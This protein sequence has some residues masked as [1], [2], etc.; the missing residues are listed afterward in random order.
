M[1]SRNAIVCALIAAAGTTA[2]AGVFS[3]TGGHAG[4][5]NDPA[6]WAGPGGTYPHLVTDSATISG[7]SDSVSLVANTALG[8]LNILGGAS[9]YS[10][11]HSLFVDGDV[12]INGIG[13]ALSVSD[14]PALR[15][16]DV[17]SLTIASGVVAMYGGLMQ[18][19]DSVL[20]DG[21]NG[22]AILGVGTV[23]MN[24]TTGD[25]VVGKGGLWALNGAGPETTLLIDR[26]ESSTSRLDM[27]HPESDIIVWDGKAVHN[28][29]P[30]AGTLGGEIRVSNVNGPSRFISDEGFIAAPS[31]RISFSGSDQVE[32]ARIDAAFM[33]SYGELNVHSKGRLVSPFVGLRGTGVIDE[34]AEIAIDSAAMLWHSFSFSATGPN[35]LVRFVDVNG[36]VSVTGGATVFDLGETGTFDLDGGG[37]MEISIADG[38]SLSIHAGSVDTGAEV[39][40]GTLNVA[41]G[42]FVEYYGWPQ[43]GWTSSGAINMQG[44]EITG[45]RFINDGTISGKGMIDT[46][47]HNDGI[48]EAVGGTLQF[49]TLDLDGSA[50]LPGTGITR[51]EEGDIV[52]TGNDVGGFHPTAGSLYV[53]NGVG[54]RE[55]FEMNNGILLYENLEGSG[56]MSLNGGFARFGRA[57]LQTEFV[58]TNDS[59][60]TISGSGEHD[61]LEFVDG[62]A[63]INGPLEV[64]GNVIVWDDATLTG[65]GTID[66][67]STVQGVML[68]NGSSTGDVSIE[69]SGGI[70]VGAYGEPSGQASAAGLM[71][72]PT[73]H[74]DVDIAGD[75]GS[76]LF[77]RL[78]IAGD[79]QVDG[80]LV[81]R[82]SAELG[83]AP[84]G[85]TY[86]VLTAGSVSGGFDGVDFSGLGTNRRAQV[87]VHADSVEVLV[88]CLTDLNAD[89]ILDLGDIS[90]FT[91]AFTDGDMLADLAPP[92]GV[93]DLNDIN[94]FVFFFQ[95]GCN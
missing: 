33:D 79:A 23:E 32:T 84:V 42:F 9:V 21:P 14:S 30:Y 3:W 86:T 45:R 73:A 59:I 51:A 47:V 89:G 55:V 74:L 57:R 54:I 48:I 11:G 64:R 60:V 2:S 83:D 77:D 43:L 81:V 16:L 38:S 52:V 28:R 87:S 75:E 69:A 67:S 76:G 49:A 56:L 22:G 94:A 92:F 18:V 71:M 50:D 4:V 82:W 58:S 15:D 10:A 39:F 36:A 44:G 20:I 65:G 26:T 91:D 35:A 62:T 68:R 93:L 5:W 46:T 78:D 31:S 7:Q 29:L 34:D 17:D 95:G 85:E 61:A 40:G 19:D 90:S 88:T 70:G 12:N 72:H 1:N 27:T 41:G 63:S 53:G 25:L 13:S 8:H 6:S 37:A 66:A 80:T 24:S